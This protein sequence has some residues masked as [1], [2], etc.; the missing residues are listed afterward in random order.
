MNTLAKELED[1]EARRSAGSISDADAA[2]AK[3]ALLQ[4][5]P[6]TGGT[7]RAGSADA[8]RR[9]PVGWIMAIVFANFL[10]TLLVLGGMAAFA[11]FVLPLTLALP[12]LIIMV[13]ILPV[14]WLIEW[15]GDLF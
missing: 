10:L 6:S 2:L 12:I 5:A 14:L 8:S 13:L 7:D 11:Y 1:L 15:F 9:G 4:R 3:Q